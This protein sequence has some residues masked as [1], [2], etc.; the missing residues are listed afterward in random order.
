MHSLLIYLANAAG[1]ASAVNLAE[2]LG[3]DPI[4][5]TPTTVAS[6]FNI[7]KLYVQRFLA[8]TV[9][10]RQVWVEQVSWGAA[11]ALASAWCRAQGAEAWE[12]EVATELGRSIQQYRL[13][14]YLALQADQP[15]GMAVIAYNQAHF[16]AARDDQVQQALFGH[17][18]GELGAIGVCS[19]QQL[20][21]FAL[22]GEVWLHLQPGTFTPAMT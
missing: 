13:M 12:L 1:L 19:E 11:R 14:A 4:L 5:L 10:N 21:G 16:W 2:Q 17:I 20:A 3:Q 7:R 15:V 9:V 22:E 8:T 18:Y 6:A